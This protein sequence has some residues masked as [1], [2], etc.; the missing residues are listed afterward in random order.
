ML[1]EKAALKKLIALLFCT[2]PQILWAAPPKVVVSIQPIHSLVASIM[3][4]VDQPHLLLP[5]DSSPHFFQ[6][7]PRDAELIHTSELII[8][9]GPELENF[10]EK[11]LEALGQDSTKLALMETDG[12]TLL[13]GSHDHHHDHDHE[14]DSQDENHSHHHDH[15]IDPHVWLSPSNASQMVKAIEQQ[16]IRLDPE[17]QKQYQDNSKAVQREI[18]RTAETMSEILA[19]VEKQPYLVFHDGYQYFNHSFGL[20]QAGHMTDNPHV[21]LSLHKIKELKQIIEDKKIVCLFSEPGA[22]RKILEQVAKDTQA[23]VGELDP[24]GVNILPG[25]DA[26]RTMMIKLANDTKACLDPALQNKTEEPDA[27]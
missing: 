18:N 5:P 15:S 23:Q 8:W 22:N 12:L 6:L 11:P 19:G 17:H 2:L 27:S 26:Y 14:K 4:G 3:E 9:V 24:L 21:P 20:N 25:P 7:R 13:S 16:L 10:L 1:L